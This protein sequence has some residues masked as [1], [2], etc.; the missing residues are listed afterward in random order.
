MHN[1]QFYNMWNYNYI[2]QQAAEQYCSD[3]MYRSF[4]CAYKLKDFLDSV[5]KVDLQF[6]E[7]MMAE[8]CAVLLEYARRHGWLSI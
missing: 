3:Q 8:C 7:H 5:D 6:Q 2:R 4:D 1:N